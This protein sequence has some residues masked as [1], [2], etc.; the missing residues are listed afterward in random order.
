VFITTCT[1][2]G[3]GFLE[4]VYEESMAIALREAGLRVQRQ[5]PVPVLFRGQ[6]VGDFRADLLVEQKVIVEL[7]AARTLERSHEAQLLHYLRATEIEIGL[8]LNLGEKPQFRRLLF[9]NDR[10]KIRAHPC[11]SVAGVGK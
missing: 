7:K 3:Y 1:E 5:V 2:L 4:S 6:Q 11:E 10:K 8:L 9:D